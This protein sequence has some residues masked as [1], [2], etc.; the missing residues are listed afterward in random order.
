MTVYVT[1]QLTI[2]DPGRYAQ[3]VA[4]FPPILAKY[5][6]RLLAV[7]SHPEVTEGQWG[8]D[9]VVLMTFPDREA[10][11]AWATSPEYL[12]IAKDRHAAADTTAILVRGL[13]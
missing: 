7:D 13:A 2:H 9:R 5:G 6:G 1:A 8:G 4:G 11:I 12:E 3:Y 10:Y